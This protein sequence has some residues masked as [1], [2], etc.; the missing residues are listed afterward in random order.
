MNSMVL[1][2]IAVVGVAI[3]AMAARARGG[4]ESAPVAEAP[5]DAPEVH[6]HG[7][8]A[9]GDPDEPSA[10]RGGD[11][12]S[13]LIVA[14]STFGHAFL[15]DLVDVRIVAPAHE[16]PE[17][18]AGA[19]IEDPLALAHATAWS[20]GDVVAARVVAG[21]GEEE[22][23]R[24]E[25]IGRDGEY[26]S[27]GFATREGAQAVLDLLHEYVIPPAD[28]ADED[29]PAVTDATYADARRVYMETLAE[30]GLESDE[31]AG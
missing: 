26:V 9:A 28:E 27:Y 24:L 31:H 6:E 19:R 11:P 10:P 20:V 14:T 5:G 18:T 29:E 2:G 21:E 15:T 25:G 17:W 13:R 3:V 4:D 7:D 1:A 8:D 12:R 16:G 30:L 22:P 23:W